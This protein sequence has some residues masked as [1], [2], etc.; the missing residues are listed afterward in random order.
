MGRSPNI[1][2][3]TRLNTRIPEDLRRK[4]DAHLYSK[5]EGR[6]PHS[7]YTNLICKLLEDYLRNIG[8]KR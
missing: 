8:A 4:L 7:A 1:H 5:A 6:V 2:E 3:P